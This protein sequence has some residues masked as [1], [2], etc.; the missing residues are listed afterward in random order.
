MWVTG[1]RIFQDFHIFLKKYFWKYS[2]KF[3]SQIFGENF[4]ISVT[5][6][7]PLTSVKI[8][9]IEG[10]YKTYYSV[11]YWYEIG[12]QIGNSIG[13]LKGFKG[14]VVK[15]KGSLRSV[16]RGAPL[17]W[18]MNELRCNLV[19]C[20]HGGCGGITVSAVE[21]HWKDIGRL[22]AGTRGAP[23]SGNALSCPEMAM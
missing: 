4:E 14:N 12:N 22:R 20:G 15:L 9:E 3:F 6:Y 16:S 23:L 2:P 13:N 7:L 19:R 11:G 5:S 10:K 1:Y 18:K 17:S 21:L 8:G